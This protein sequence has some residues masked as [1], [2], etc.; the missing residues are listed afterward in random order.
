M[1]R[2]QL[3]GE[4]DGHL[5]QE[6]ETRFNNIPISAFRIPIMFKSVGRCS[7]MDYTVGREKGL[8]G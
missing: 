4:R 2:I 6:S 5:M 3:E 8:K 7:E 1:K